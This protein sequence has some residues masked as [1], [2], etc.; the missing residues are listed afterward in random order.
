MSYF[1]RVA[2]GKR[3]Q[4]KREYLEKGEE[5]KKWSR[6]VLH[7]SRRRGVLSILAHKLEEAALKRNSHFRLQLYKRG[8]GIQQVWV[9]E[10]IGRSVIELTHLVA[11]SFHL[12]GTALNEYFSGNLL[13]IQA[14]YE[15]MWQEYMKGAPFLSKQCTK[16]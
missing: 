10:R 8:I 2:Q 13:I 4:P 12:F 7:Y 9:N 16:G 14:S 6:K 1:R 5:R 11:V 3:I 15:N